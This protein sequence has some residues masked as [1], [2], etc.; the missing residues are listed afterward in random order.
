MIAIPIIDDQSIVNMR[1][2]YKLNKKMISKVKRSYN[3][4]VI[5]TT[6]VRITISFETRSR[7]IVTPLL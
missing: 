1:V 2:I 3:Q 4:L 5:T 7:N 6:L